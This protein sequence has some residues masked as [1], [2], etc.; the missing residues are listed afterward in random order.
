MSS[1]SYAYGRYFLL[2]TCRFPIL[3]LWP[4]YNHGN[5][6][7]HVIVH[8]CTSICACIHTDHTVITVWMQTGPILTTR[9]NRAFQ[10]VLFVCKSQP[11]ARLASNRLKAVV[12]ARTNS[13]LRFANWQ[14]RIGLL[15]LDRC[16]GLASPSLQQDWPLGILPIIVSDRD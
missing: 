7:V 5:R 6:S 13:S 12:N 9:S 1:I 11:P 16:F 4:L 8:L 3:K 10:I 15:L 2:L 14:R